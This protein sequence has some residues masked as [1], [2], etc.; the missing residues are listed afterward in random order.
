[1][2]VIFFFGGFTWD[3]LT[4][5]RIDRMSDNLILLS[6]L[7]LLGLL[8]VIFNFV[9][10]GLLTRSWLLKYREWYPLGMQFFLGGLFSSYVVFYFQSA[11]MTKT[12]IFL[13]LLVILL[14]ANEFLE[15]R[16]SNLNLVLSL[17]FFASFSFFIFFIPVIVKFMNLV[18]YVLGGMISLVLIGLL[19][20][21]FYRKKILVDRKHLL[22]TSSP[23]L[24]IYMLLNIFYIQNWIP[25]VPLALKSAGI[26]HHVSR[27]GTDYVLHY[28]K[29]RW[30]EFWKK[31]DDP[32]HYTSGD[33]VFCFTAIFA[34]TRL[35][36]K[37]FHHWQKY[38][39][40]RHT[41][42]T[43]DR[44]GYEIT[45]GR[46]GGYRGYTYK[47]NVSPGKWRVNVETE[48]K[49]LLGRIQFE[50]KFVQ[51]RVPLTMALK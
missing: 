31:S 37:T 1:M 41:W 43:T 29:P 32:F 34:P 33:T 15:K 4:L 28:E 5:T 7:I 13:L 20:W 2:P 18:T 36:K 9:E 11:S 44:L 8:I 25:P 51:G 40:E 39:P 10:N 35:T 46:E 14:V 22:L 30:Y 23:V 12:A 6:Y 50:I 42:V 17:Y 26:Y 3:S 48:E 19:L 24:V 16:L 38:L 47:K 27:E 49:L 21:I 45:G